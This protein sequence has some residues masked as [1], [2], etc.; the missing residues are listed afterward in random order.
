MD[1]GLVLLMRG[2]PRRDMIG[3]VRR[4]IR[5]IILDGVA[6]SLMLPLVVIAIFWVRSYYMSEALTYTRENLNVTVLDSNWGSLIVLTRSVIAPEFRQPVRSRPRQPPRFQYQ[7]TPADRL[8][9]IGVR[10]NG[11][12]R[13]QYAGFWFIRQPAAPWQH[14]WVIIIPFWAIALAA[15]VPAAYSLHLSRRYGLLLWRKRNRLC[16]SCGYD[17]R[18]SFD[19]CPECGEEIGIQTHTAANQS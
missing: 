4:R 5:R 17:L 2:D 9:R 19:R 16:L 18:A 12:V 7:A 1:W 8:G 13:A 3:G 14:G 10:L 15:C 11:T 6:I